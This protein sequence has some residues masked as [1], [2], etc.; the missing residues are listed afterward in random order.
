MDAHDRFKKRLAL[1]AERERVKEELAASLPPEPC[2]SM[3]PA[4]DGVAG[5]ADSVSPDEADALIREIGEKLDEG[6]VS[7]LIDAC[8]RE[9]LQ[10][11]IRPFVIGR[12]LFEDKLGGNVATIHNV[13]S[14]EYRKSEENTAWKQAGEESKYNAAMAENERKKKTY[15]EYIKK[16]KAHKKWE[17]SGR[18]GPEPERPSPAVDPKYQYRCRNSKYRDAKKKYKQEQSDGTLYN[19]FNGEY[20][21]E[22]DV[23]HVEHAYSC[24]QIETDPAVLLAEL[25]GPDLANVDENLNP[26]LG[27]INQSKNDLSPEEA[28]QMWTK[29]EPKRLQQ[30]HVLEEMKMQGKLSPEGEARLRKLKQLQSI[31]EN[32]LIDAVNK[33]KSKI[34]SVVNCKYYTSKKFIMNTMSTGAVEGGRMGLQQ[35]VGVLMEEF[36]RAA[37][38]EV[39]DAWRNGFKGKVDSSFLQALR[40]RLERVALC[41]ADK[42]KDAAIAFRDGFVSGFLSNIITVVINAFVTTRARLVRIIREGFLS[43]YKA[44]RILAFPDDGMSLDEAADAASKLLAAGLVTG[45][46][47]LIEEAVEKIIITSGPLAPVAPYLSSIIVGLVT[48]LA[49]VF[50]MYFLD[51][52]DLFGVQAKDRHEHVVTKLNEMLNVSYEHALESSAVFDGPALLHVPESAS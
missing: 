47:I 18:P 49:T 26:M 27:H 42:W 48:G 43:L 11:I 16:W 35:A 41:V 25:Y 39:K 3:V 24:E 46:G 21:S 6:K 20:F 45:G 12:V 31:D 15:S 29:E 9:C 2:R 33:G 44:I 40:T 5:G 13:R 22:N 37:F 51:H 23:V 7:A 50:A 32:A 34:D 17:D 10:A 30:I 19:A 14:E 52:L 4:F 36:V 1:A 8:E 28:I 38:F